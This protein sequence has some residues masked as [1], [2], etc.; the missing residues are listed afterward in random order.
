M[1]GS[2]KFAISGALLA[3]AMAVSGTASAAWYSI[4]TPSDGG[5]NY[6]DHK[7]DD[8]SSCN[9]GFFL[10]GTGGYASG[11]CKHERPNTS[12]VQGNAGNLPSGG[13]FWGTDGG[14]K[15][16]NFQFAGGTY[17]LTFLGSLAGANPV[18]DFGYVDGTGMHSLFGSAITGPN[19]SVTN[20][21][22]VTI[23][24][25]G[26]W[27]FYVSLYNPKD[28]KAYSFVTDGANTQF[29]L[30]TTDGRLAGDTS[31]F[32]NKSGVPFWVG[33]EDNMT[34]SSDFDF[35]DFMIR[36][37]AASVPEPA[38]LGLLGF[39]LLGAGVAARRRKK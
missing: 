39:G 11:G 21:Q 32:S 3:G 18:R 28:Q 1:K 2:I 30:F 27:S 25:S 7:S 12:F 9:V 24:A 23:N 13:F 16:G 33:I 38:T 14:A 19:G 37:N 22:S 6:W 36:I 31:P 26:D 34:K 29:A 10:R 5:G 4:G 35:N 15:A 17:S 8:G 20:P